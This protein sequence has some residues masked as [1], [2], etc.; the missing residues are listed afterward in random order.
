MLKRTVLVV[1]DNEINR[2]MLTAILSSEYRVLEAE[3]GQE[4]L[5]LLE[6]YKEG[7]SLIFFRY[8]HACNGRL[9]LSFCNEGQSGLFFHS[10][11]CSYA[12]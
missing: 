7:I 8:Y 9:Y 12:K 6:Q 10:G 1:E 5:V 4:A 3:N 11:Y 2:E